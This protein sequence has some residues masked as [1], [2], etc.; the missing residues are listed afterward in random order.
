MFCCLDD[1]SY[2]AVPIPQTPQ[3]PQPQTPC[4]KECRE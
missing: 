4:D 2:V 3:I 1:T